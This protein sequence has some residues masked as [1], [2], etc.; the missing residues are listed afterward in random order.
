VWLSIIKTLSL[1]CRISWSDTLFLVAYI[2]PQRGFIVIFLFMH[3]IH[4]D[5]FPMSPAMWCFYRATD[6][7]QFKSWNFL[8]WVTIIFKKVIP[9]KYLLK[10]MKKRAYKGLCKNTEANKWCHGFMIPWTWDYLCRNSS[11]ASSLPPSGLPLWWPLLSSLVTQRPC[12]LVLNSSVLSTLS[13]TG[14]EVCATF[15]HTYLNVKSDF[16]SPSNWEIYYTL[17]CFGIYHFWEG[18][19]NLFIL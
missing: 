8:W 12:F 19:P 10:L 13:T 1:S 11:L 16:N 9:Q 6:T 7:V 3:I 18:G 5:H 2:N 15:A 17:F 14:S 4:F